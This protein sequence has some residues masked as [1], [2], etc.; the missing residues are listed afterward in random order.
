MALVSIFGTEVWVAQP[1]K[2]FKHSDCLKNIKINLKPFKQG[3]TSH[4]W[5]YISRD[6]N[7]NL[8]FISAKMLCEYSVYNEEFG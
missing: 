8:N 1:T 2:K 3:D 6:I 4:V 7:T 5:A